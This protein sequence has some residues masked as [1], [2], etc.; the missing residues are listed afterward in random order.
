MGSSSL[1]SPCWTTRGSKT[2]NNCTWLVVISRCRFACH[3]W[4]ARKSHIAGTI[5]MPATTNPAY[6]TICGG[7]RPPNCRIAPPITAPTPKPNPNPPMT[8][9]DIQAAESAVRRVVRFIR[10]TSS[11]VSFRVV[12]VWFIFTYRCGNFMPSRSTGVTRR[13][14]CRRAGSSRSRWGYRC[15]NGRARSPQCRPCA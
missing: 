3:F 14:K 6:S 10:T 4:N 11:S 9:N 15:G 1:S 2:S 8:G 13:A 5:P 12:R 7:G